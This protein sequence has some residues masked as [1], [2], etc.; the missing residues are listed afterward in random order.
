MSK[1]KRSGPNKLANEK[2]PYLLQHAHNPVDWYPW[3][4]EVFARAKAEDKPIFLSIGY[5]T[6]HW[7]HVMERESFEDDQ[8]AEMLNRHFLAVKVDREERPDVDQLYMTVCQALT[9]RGGW[10][11]TILMTPDR[12]PF[13]AGTY[14]PKISQRQMPGLLDI[15]AHFA[16]L[17]ANDRS[18]IISS[19]DQVLAA[20]KT[21]FAAS[22]PGEL[23]EAALHQSFAELAEG[24]DADWG[25]FNRAPKFPT[26]HVLSFL[27]RYGKAFQ[28]ET[29]LAM[30]EKTLSAIF[31]GGIH[32]H[33]GGGY[34][35]YATDQPWLI[36]HFEKMLYDNALLAI[37]FLETHQAT[38]RPGYAQAAREILDYILREMTSAEGGFYSAEDADS[39][40]V[41]GKYYLWTA[42]EAAAVLGPEE[43]AA[44]AAAFGISKNG[45]FEGKSI[46]NLIGQKEFWQI[47]ENFRAAKTP[48]RQ[49][50]DLRIHPFKDDKILAGWNGLM[51]AAMAMAGR[52]LDAPRFTAAG[53]SAAR[54]VLGNMR[55]P[56]GRLL[57]RYRDRS[58]AI[59]AFLDDY[60]FLTWGLLELY[61]TDFQADDLAS[62]LTLSR[63]LLRYFWDE[64]KGGCFLS[65]SDGEKLF[66]RSKEIHDGAMPSG[67]SVTALNFLRLARLTADP[68]WEDKARQ[69]LTAFG[70]AVSGH[71]SSHCHLL[72]ALQ[73]SVGP[74]REVVIAGEDLTARRWLKN[75]IRD[76]FLPESV[77][78]ITSDAL[79]K[80]LPFYQDYQAL[81]GSPTAYICSGFTCQ[82]PLTDGEL[83]RQKLRSI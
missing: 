59:P 4:D 14:F 42:E 74:A 72:M 68:L 77:F 7:C 51:I 73:L 17:W 27:L 80:L 10:P 13:F 43:G 53:H 29:A 64:E 36:P 33:I 50:R 9:G 45:N 52:I 2:S 37:A 38:G 48:L 22:H 1:E 63:D 23:G 28:N 25:G 16:G 19:S 35:R 62:A 76:L 6:C 21:H 11:L 61:Q 57:A 54:F 79:K 34:A 58:A 83:L 49:A 60:A 26:P 40:G 15:L 3:G 24:F 39:E 8:V 5:S 70:G 75:A 20:I 30:V 12:K 69:I 65:G 55:R 71:P 32:D 56:D 78:L 82:P 46:P 44:F 31:Q 18:K 47:A 66:S 67:N 81:G 41:E